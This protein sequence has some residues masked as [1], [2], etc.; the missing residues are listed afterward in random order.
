[1]FKKGGWIV[2]VCLVAYLGLYTWNWKT[3]YLDR[4][5]TNT[6]LEAVGWIM[7]PG[8]F[9]RDEAEDLWHRYIYLVDVR[10]DNERLKSRLD[11]AL[12]ELYALRARIREAD[13]L[14]GLL[15]FNPP[16]EWEMQG[17]RIVGHSLGITGV[18]ETVIVDK[19]RRDGVKRDQPVVCPQGAVG[20]VFKV[21]SNFSQ[22][23]LLTDPNSRLPVISR[24]NRIQAI[25]VGQGPG[26]PLSINYVP[27]NV[28]LN[29]NEELI[30]SG[31]AG[32]FPKGFPVARVSEIQISD[33][34]LFQ[35]VKASPLV[36]IG[37]LEQL[38]ILNSAKSAE[39]RGMLSSEP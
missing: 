24:T 29:D 21:S 27:L 37:S 15:G 1:M 19:G 10:R 34:S 28:P 16:P 8:N 35:I 30:T 25:A 18:L 31:L 26:A 9:V 13:R 3:H 6:G 32:V 14:E 17:A 33:V 7:V 22:V 39:Q 23:L 4:L 2:I 20:R 36:N 11:S 5:A 12:N 38:F